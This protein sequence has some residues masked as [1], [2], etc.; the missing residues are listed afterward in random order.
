MKIPTLLLVPA[1]ILTL[2]LLAHAEPLQVGAA[3]PAASGVDQE[4][5][6]VDFQ[7]IY[8]KGPTLVYFYPKADT[9]GCTKEGCSIR[10]NWSALQTKGIQ[11]IG[12]SEDTVGEE[13][14]FHDKFKF[15]FALVADH[16]GKVATAFGVPTNGG[17]AKRQSFLIKDGKIIWNMLDKTT[18]ET[19]ATDVLKAYEELS[20]K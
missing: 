8:A 17:H 4:G 18:T 10:D 9:P 3:A 14:A 11:V 5:N 20:K 6:A 12:V 19:H 13:K 2:G 1:S 16:D 15:P 7:A